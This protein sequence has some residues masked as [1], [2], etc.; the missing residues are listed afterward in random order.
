[1][2][3]AR[4]ADHVRSRSCR[5]A[6]R[7]SCKISL[8]STVV[9]I[10]ASRPGAARVPRAATVEDAA[11]G[12]GEA[13]AKRPRR[14]RARRYAQYAGTPSTPTPGR[15]TAPPKCLIIGGE[16]PPGTAAPPRRTAIRAHFRRVFCC[17]HAK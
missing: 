1:L 10:P 11:C 12:T 16:S 13:G 6:G 17:I 8:C 2:R 5:K 14:C 9:T 15:V 7:L 3:D 4:P